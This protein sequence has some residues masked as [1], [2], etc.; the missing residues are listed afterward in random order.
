[1]YIFATLRLVN[2]L[3]FIGRAYLDSTVFHKSQ[4]RNGE[5]VRRD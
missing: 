4:H 2:L 5:G 3:V 1:M